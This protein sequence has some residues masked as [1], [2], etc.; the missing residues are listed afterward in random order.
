MAA[1]D[2]EKTLGCAFAFWSL[3]VVTPMWLFLLF[4]LMLANEMPVW[5]WVL[6]WCYVPANIIGVILHHLYKF[7]VS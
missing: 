5:S 6:F 7:I 3:F 1:T 2:E 4:G